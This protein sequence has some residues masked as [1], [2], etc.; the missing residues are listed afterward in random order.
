MGSFIHFW[1]DY[2]F[3]I[4]VLEIVYNSFGWHKCLQ[5]IVHLDT[6]KV[7]GYF[8]FEVLRMPRS[9]EQEKAKLLRKR[10]LLEEKGGIIE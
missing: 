9:S 10:I 7:Y 1:Q 6:G 2:S 4:V 5:I 3:E 8:Y